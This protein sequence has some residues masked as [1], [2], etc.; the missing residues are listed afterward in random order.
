MVFV[1]SLVVGMVRHVVVSGVRVMAMVML[2][3]CVAVVDCL[4]LMVTV[5]M[6]CHSLYSLAI[7]L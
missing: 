6:P 5:M 7:V 4:V 3:V 1:V 2:G